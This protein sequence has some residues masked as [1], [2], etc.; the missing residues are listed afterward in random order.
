[1]AVSFDRPTHTLF[2]SDR[3]VVATAKYTIPT[4]VT[5]SNI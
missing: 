2:C 5:V 1:M 3:L 4:N